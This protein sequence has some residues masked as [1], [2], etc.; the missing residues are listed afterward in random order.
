M[1]DESMEQLKKKMEEM[2]NG[3]A[4]SRAL[5][6]SLTNAMGE[7]IKRSL[8]K[9]L[10]E[11]PDDIYAR[12]NLLGFRLVEIPDIAGRLGNAIIKLDDEEYL[13]HEQNL[14]LALDTIEQT[15]KE[16]DVEV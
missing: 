14:A 15:L 9:Q 12:K 2:A 13:K 16:L 1:I 8:R 6:G 11:N 5:V 10:E 7:V 4:E 3:D